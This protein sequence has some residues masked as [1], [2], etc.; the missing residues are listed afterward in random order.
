MKQKVSV[1]NVAASIAVNNYS[2]SNQLTVEAI[3]VDVVGGI[4]EK[5]R[6]I[7]NAFRCLEEFG[8]L[9]LLEIEPEVYNIHI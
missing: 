4:R 9:G 6:A 3:F 5:Y 1:F 2:V 7:A 8:I